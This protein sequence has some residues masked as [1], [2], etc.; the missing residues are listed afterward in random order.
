MV[1]NLDEVQKCR[2]VKTKTSANT[3]EGNIELIDKLELAFNF[4][5]KR[6]NE[7]ALEFFNAEPEGLLLND[8]LQLIEKWYNIIQQ[9]IPQINPKK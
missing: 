7:I 9:H 4:T 5:D 1:V 8:E 3:K 2:I 6:K